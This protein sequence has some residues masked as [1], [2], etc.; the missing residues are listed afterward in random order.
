M[1]DVEFIN[2]EPQKLDGLSFGSQQANN[3]GIKIKGD[4][5]Q[6]RDFPTFSPLISTKKL[7]NITNFIL[8]ANQY[9]YSFSSIDGIDIE[10]CDFM[11]IHQGGVNDHQVYIGT[12]INQS[13]KKLTLKRGYI[14]RSP[15]SLT[16]GIRAAAAR[17]RNDNIRRIKM[18][19]VNMLS[20]VASLESGP[21]PCTIDVYSRSKL[22]AAFSFM[23]MGI[24]TW[25]IGDL[26]AS[27]ASKVV[28]ESMSISHTGLK[29]LPVTS[30]VIDNFS[31][32]ARSIVDTVS[33]APSSVLNFTKNIAQDYKDS[34]QNIK[35]DWEDNTLKNLSNTGNNIK[36][37]FK[38]LTGV[39]TGDKAA[40]NNSANTA[41]RGENAGAGKKATNFP[42]ANNSLKNAENAAKI[43]NSEMKKAYKEKNAAEKEAKH[44]EQEVKDAEEAVNK[45]K[46]EAEKRAAYGTLAETKERMQA[47]KKVLRNAD[48]KV[49]A[50]EKNKG[51][52][53]DKLQESRDELMESIS[54]IENEEERAKAIQEALEQSEIDLAYAIANGDKELENHH[55]SMKESLENELANT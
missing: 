37:S 16:N 38:G 41:G 33:N 27:D 13:E 17:I 12:K 43:N 34:V 51:E 31:V 4:P 23:S 9:A 11:P 19:E 39:F 50:L 52:L 36:S 40:D 44:L 8:T 24:T 45:A 48:E 28:I 3:R 22:I 55:K 42:T 10:L 14:L 46:D 53:L 1:S 30:S 5:R 32:A 18:T 2:Q 21:T 6:I 35:S 47:Q 25:E 20:W 26:D 29:R 7:Y 54:N 49:S 15:E